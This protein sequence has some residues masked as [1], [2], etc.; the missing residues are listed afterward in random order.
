[1]DWFWLPNDVPQEVQPERSWF[2]FPHRRNSRP[3]GF[4]L[5]WHNALEIRQ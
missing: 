2:D 5:R 3:G 1:M 4:N